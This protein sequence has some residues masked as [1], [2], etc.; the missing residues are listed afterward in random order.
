MLGLG[1]TVSTRVVGYPTRE[2]LTGGESSY[3]GRMVE[4]SLSGWRE[5]RSTCPIQQ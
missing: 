5:R 2:P 3:S 4:A 1:V